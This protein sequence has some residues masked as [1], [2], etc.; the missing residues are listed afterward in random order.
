MGLGIC[1]K[2]TSDHTLNSK[3]IKGIKVPIDLK[4]FK[5]RQVLFI[6]IFYLFIYFVFG[7][8]K[9]LGQGLYL[10]TAATQAAAM[11][12]PDL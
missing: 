5:Q 1:R 4:D 6:F 12:M 8:W 11:T 7:R 2:L 3:V 10:I 9:F